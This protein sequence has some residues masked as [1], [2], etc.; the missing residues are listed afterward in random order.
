MLSQDANNKMKNVIWDDTPVD[1]TEEVN[2]IWSI[3]NKLRGPYQS[4]KYKNVI[5][6]MT[7]I[8]RFECA[9]EQTKQAVLDKVAAM[10]NVPDKVL[11]KTAGY[12][13][14][15]NSNFAQEKQASTCVRCRAMT[16]RKST[17]CTAFQTLVP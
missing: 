8:R 15:N 16:P 10:P 11:Y 17:S 1:V 6:P 7:I 14:Y 12:A 9:L 2:L 4:D 5:I 13:F 3:A